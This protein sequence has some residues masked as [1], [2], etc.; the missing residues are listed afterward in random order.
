LGT[1]YVVGCADYE[2]SLNLKSMFLAKIAA[3]G[4][5]L[6]LDRYNSTNAGS[7]FGKALTIDTN[8]NVYVTGYV[9]N[10]QGGSEFVTIKYSASPKIQNKPDDGMHLEFHTIPGKPYAIE[11]TTNFLNWQSLITNT[12]DANGL[13]RFDDTNSPTIPFRF[14]RGNSSP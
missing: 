2:N 7:N 13:I 14:Y 11:G 3:S 5:Q 9:L 10:T 12:A 4:Q 8:D 1:L 6:G